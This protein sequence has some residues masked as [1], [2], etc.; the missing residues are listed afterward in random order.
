M[1]KK[2]NSF[3]ICYPHGANLLN[4]HVSTTRSPGQGF[5]LCWKISTVRLRNLHS[6]P[7]FE[8]E[9][10]GANEIPGTVDLNLV[11]EKRDGVKDRF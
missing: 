3:L 1:N 5:K 2:K 6:R 9:V 11:Q 8:L 10:P 7:A 4:I